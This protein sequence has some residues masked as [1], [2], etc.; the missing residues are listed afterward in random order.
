VKS[1]RPPL[2]ASA[3]LL[4]LAIGCGPTRAALPAGDA[5][6]SLTGSGGV[7]RPEHR[8]KPH[9]ILISFDGF[10]AD[11]LDRFELPNFRRVLA[12]GTRARGMQPVF[13]SLTFP[14]HYS[15]VTGM[16]PGRH[17]LVN[18]NFYDPERKQRYAMSDRAAV[19][20]GSWYGG[21]PIWV[22]AETQGMVAA[23][24]FWPG[25]EAAIKGVRPTFWQ[26][27]DDEVP[28]T[29]RVQT[30]L[31]W[32]QLPVEKRPHVIT[33]YFSDLD[34]AAHDATIDSPAVAAAAQSVDS[35]L[36]E[37]L[38]G[39]DA[40]PIRDRVWLLLTSDHGMVETSAAKTVRLETLLDTSD[41]YASYGGAVA[42]LHIRGGPERAQQVREAINATLTHGRAYL[43]AEVPEHHHFRA[44]P[45]AGD[46]IV[47]MDEA[48]TLATAERRP[49]ER[50]AVWGAHGWDPA[51]PSMR[52]LFVAAGPGIRAG[53][54]IDDVQNVDVYPLM[55]ELLGLRPAA[56]IDGTPGRIR[57]QLAIGGRTPTTSDAYDGVVR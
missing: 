17:G 1:K 54:T 5:A 43:R 39:L 12:R 32:L 45:R 50:P 48:W 57:A 19:E 30:V 29:T 7:N 15:L 33:L 9:L 3:I 49:R 35:T 55:T 27:F 22:T 47:I 31:E 21:E 40:L 16:H 28:N 34:S 14:N 6:A 41:V 10:R 2:L 37:L 18:N 11:Y 25:S 38:N 36:G 23:C 53:A 8:D 24:F 56:G 13:P 51:L 52:A 20:D 4:A 42:S 44:D 26:R 46:V